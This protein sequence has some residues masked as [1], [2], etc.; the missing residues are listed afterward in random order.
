MT[1]SVTTFATD[2]VSAS[3]LN[4]L[5]DAISSEQAE[6]G[7]HGGVPDDE[8]SDDAAGAADEADITSDSTDEAYAALVLTD[9]FPA[10]KSPVIIS[11]DNA[12][13]TAS[14]TNDFD[15]AAG[16]AGEVVVTSALTDEASTAAVPTELY[17]TV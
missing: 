12:I 15:V 1:L 3:T 10:D 14:Q 11:A 13:L 7:S 9:G 5:N 6:S 8:P 2:E 4:G 17:Y 16:V